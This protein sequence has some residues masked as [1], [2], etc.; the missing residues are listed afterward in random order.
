MW[1]SRPKRKGPPRLEPY[2]DDVVTVNSREQL[3]EQLGRK[4]F[5]IKRNGRNRWAILACP[6]GCGHRIEANLMKSIYPH[7]KL[8]RRRSSVSLSPS[9]WVAPDLCGSHFRL[10]ANRVLWVDLNGR[11]W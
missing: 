6:C 8:R 7:W 4:I 1:L 5:V 10:V 9:L 11:R 2:Y 3:P